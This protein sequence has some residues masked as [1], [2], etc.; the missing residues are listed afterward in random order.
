MVLELA[1][2]LKIGGGIACFVIF[3]FIIIAGFR[4]NSQQHKPTNGS[5]VSKTTPK[6]ESTTETNTTE[7]K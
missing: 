6:T 7:T 4:T 3:L 5:K 2:I 1:T